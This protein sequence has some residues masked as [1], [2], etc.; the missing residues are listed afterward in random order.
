MS[1]PP[2]HN[3]KL[4]LCQAVIALMGIVSAKCVRKY[5]GKY[6]TSIPRN[7]SNAVASHLQYT[8]SNVS[9]TSLNR[10]GT[11]LSMRVLIRPDMIHFV[12]GSTS[13]FRRRQGGFSSKLP[14]MPTEHTERKDCFTQHH[15]VF[16]AKT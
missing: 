3:I 12:S 4:T 8:G 2:P 6:C 5:V 14:E 13:F 16:K 9:W 11:G 1:P 7:F 15:G 10:I